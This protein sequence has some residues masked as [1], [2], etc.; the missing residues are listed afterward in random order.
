M[1]VAR[2]VSR[3]WSAVFFD[4]RVW[5]HLDNDGYQ[6]NGLLVNQILSKCG[7]AIR[8]F[9]F[10]KPTHKSISKVI[11]H[12]QMLAELVLLKTDPCILVELLNSSVLD[13]SSRNLALFARLKRLDVLTDDPR[14]RQSAMHAPQANRC[15]ELIASAFPSLEGIFTVPISCCLH[16][17]N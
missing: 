9:R 3:R 15:L 17:Q 13:Q 14:A 6:I 8:S 4:A 11:T 1:F 10:V 2:A 12:C 5:R 16:L 7:S